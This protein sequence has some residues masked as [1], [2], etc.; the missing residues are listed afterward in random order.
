MTQSSLDNKIFCVTIKVRIGEQVREI[1]EL[2]L[3]V[4]NMKKVLVSVIALTSL[5]GCGAY[6]DYYKGGVRYTQD[7]Q[8]CI[9]YAGEYGRNFSRYVGGLDNAK[10]I[11]YRNTRCEDLYAMDMFGQAPRQDRQI[12]VPAAQEV[13]CN[14]C[15]QVEK[16]SCNSCEKSQP[17][18]KRRYIIVPAM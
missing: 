11:V 15:S 6:Y 16:V 8:D 12:L 3:G 9:Y 1:T 10:K 2:N 18:L 4:R 5:A 17:V 13:P 7:G 14:A